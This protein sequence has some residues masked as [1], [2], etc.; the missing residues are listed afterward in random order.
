VWFYSSDLAL[1][2]EIVVA[3][4]LAVAIGAWLRRTLP[5]VVAA[6]V[7]FLPLLFASGWAVR[8]FTPTRLTT[9][10]S[11][12]ARADGGWGIQT[13]NGMLYHPASQYWPLQ[14]VFLV[15]LLAIAAV[16]LAAGWHAT[17]TRAV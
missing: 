3:F 17:R 5:A 7:A 11:H 8:R 1:A 2:G 13:G 12:I 6:W 9:S 15:I 10:P 14:A 16:L 4:A